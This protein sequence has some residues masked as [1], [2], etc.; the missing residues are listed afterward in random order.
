MLAP[1]MPH[2]G[3]KPILAGTGKN[4]KPHMPAAIQAPKFAGFQPALL[5][6]LGELAANNNRA[7]FDANRQRYE[8]SVLCPAL[9]FV[10]AMAPRLEKISR[11]FE[12][13]PRR[14]GGSLLRVYR[15][16]RFSA[17]KTPYKS[18]LG[19]QFRHVVGRDIHAPGFYFHIEPGDCFIGV[20][21]WHP[22][23]GALA[24]IRARIADKP[25]LW[26]QVLDDK[27]FRR[28]FTFAGDSLKR[29]PKGY[30]GGH[31]LIADLRRKDFIAIKRLDDD[32][33][34]DDKLTMKVASLFA[35]GAPLMQF[36]CAALEVDY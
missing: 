7:W 6:F 33:L 26:R 18:N 35:A 4:P 22:H 30:A 1:G 11:R 17:D 10:A 8:D 14:S 34:L 20:G 24:K 28:Q 9:D 13:I 25:Q 3:R 29:P 12:A 21:S 5:G 32:A 19:I 2:P 31:P 15:D 23:P 16:T 36:L 27:A